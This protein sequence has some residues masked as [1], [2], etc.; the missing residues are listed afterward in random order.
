MAFDKYAV[1]HEIRGSFFGVRTSFN[2]VVSIAKNSALKD[3]LTT[4]YTL[5]PKGVKAAVIPMKESHIS[6]NEDYIDRMRVIRYQIQ[7]CS[8]HNGVGDGRDAY[9][10]MF[11]QLQPVLSEYHE[12]DV[13]VQEELIRNQ[14]RY[15]LDLKVEE[16]KSKPCLESDV[17]LVLLGIPPELVRNNEEFRRVFGQYLSQI[18]QDCGT[19]FIKT[20]YPHGGTFLQATQKGERDCHTYP[21]FGT[22][23]TPES[24]SAYFKLRNFDGTSLEN[25]LSLF[26]ELF[27]PEQMYII[28]PQKVQ[29]G[30]PKRRKESELMHA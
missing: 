1:G 2:D 8:N 18:G 29:F 6:V 30:L 23:K 13:P 5:R 17:S 3:I 20:F 12:M 11:N 26:G 25:E 4:L 15:G 19:Q 22:Q 9:S 10:F 16:Y 28:S 7:S 27:K 14:Y 21:E 24:G